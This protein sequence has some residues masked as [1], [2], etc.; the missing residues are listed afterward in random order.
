[1]NRRTAILALLVAPM[2]EATA[3]PAVVAG[4]KPA[5]LTLDLSRWSGVTVKYPG[6]P[7]LRI[8]A[9]EIYEALGDA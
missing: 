4:T 9:K 1:M 3:E 2:A 6:R 7:D 5:E 8:T